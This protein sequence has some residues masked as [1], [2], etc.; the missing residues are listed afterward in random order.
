MSDASVQALDIASTSLGITAN[1]IANISTDD[2]CPSR[3]DAATGRDGY[4]VQ[5]ADIL[6]APADP[7]GPDVVNHI[8][9][10]LT[11][12]NHVDLPHEIVELID[13]ENTFAANTQ[14]IRTE[15]DMDRVLLD[16][17]V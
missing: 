9:Q 6:S 14:M 5:V 13:T 12:N 7:F 17:I 16:M 10:G 3:V 2:F 4:G 15:Q 1:N 11:S 8:T